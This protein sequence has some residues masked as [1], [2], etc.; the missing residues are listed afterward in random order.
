MQDECASRTSLFNRLCYALPVGW[1]VRLVQQCHEGLNIDEWAGIAPQ[2]NDGVD[3]SGFRGAAEV[4]E[5]TQDSRVGHILKELEKPYGGAA[6]LLD[7]LVNDTR[8]GG[9]ALMLTAFGQ[10][11]GYITDI[12]CLSNILE[13]NMQD[14]SFSPLGAAAIC[15]STYP[16]PLYFKSYG[17]GD[18]VNIGWVQLLRQMH[19]LSSTDG[20]VCVMLMG[21]NI[22]YQLEGQ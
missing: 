15:S 9:E 11:S 14:S 18:S 19:L 22:M 8:M 6:A 5:L 1:Q 13:Q 20:D 7:L 16:R 12:A 21:D 10:Q 4:L 17:R 3:E 2:P